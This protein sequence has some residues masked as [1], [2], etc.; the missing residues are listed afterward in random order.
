[1][2][3]IFLDL[4]K[5]SRESK[6]TLAWDKETPREV[7]T[8]LYD[9]NDYDI[10]LMLAQNPNTEFKLLYALADKKKADIN[11]MLAE[12][13]NVPEKILISMFE[14]DGEFAPIQSIATNPKTPTSVLLSIVKL[15]L[16]LKLIA[17]SEYASPDLLDY[18]AS[19]PNLDDLDKDAR[20]ALMG[21]P[22]VKYAT[23]LRLYNEAGDDDSALDD[24]AFNDTF[25]YTFFKDFIKE[26]VDEDGVK[27]L[28]IKLDE[29]NYHKLTPKME[30]ILYTGHG[31]E[32][33][34]VIARFSKNEELLNKA[35]YFNEYSFMDL[36]SNPNATIDILKYMLFRVHRNPATC[37]FTFDE[38]KEAV[39]KS[40]AIK[41]KKDLKEIQKYLKKLL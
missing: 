40:P 13:P 24:L 6:F 33:I 7:L 9:E 10:C 16:C 25:L 29:S 36:A 5:L 4:D 27:K 18:I 39:L 20:R 8:M 28:V 11:E 26:V 17:G 23:L 15:G 31:K 38:M 41:S 2:R 30:N 19:L 12:N 35:L 34:K 37:Y 1:M 22:R 3:R 21:N 32:I 14:R